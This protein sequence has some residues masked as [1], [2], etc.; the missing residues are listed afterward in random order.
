M[1]APCHPEYSMAGGSVVPRETISLSG[2]ESQAQ[3]QDLAMLIRCKILHGV[4]SDKGG[5][6]TP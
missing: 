2:V 3:A 1:Y 4:Q 5:I 6:A